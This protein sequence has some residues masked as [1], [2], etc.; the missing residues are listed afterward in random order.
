MIKGL[1]SDLDG[2]LV[3]PW[4]TT[5]LPGAVDVLRVLRERSVQIGVG[6]NQAGPAWR[7]ITGQT[8]FPTE[9]QV[10]SNILEI[11]ETLQLKQDLWIISLYDPRLAVGRDENEVAEAMRGILRTMLSLLQPHLLRVVASISPD[12]RKPNPGMLDY[13]QTEWRLPRAEMAY[14]G[15]MD[16]DQQAAENAKMRFFH[17]SQI[18]TLLEEK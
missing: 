9:A 16:T 14:L 5:P 10:A 15:D 4:K 13:A 11:A 6:T 12:F 17:A 18:Q 1:F 8:K 3:V 7:A 2:T